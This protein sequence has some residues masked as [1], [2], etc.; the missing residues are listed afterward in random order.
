MSQTD[1]F[2]SA[3]TKLY[4][5]RRPLK[6]DS[7][8]KKAAEEAKIKLQWDD[9]GRITFLDFDD[10]KKLLELLGSSMLSPIE[11][12]K[13]LEDAKS[14][15]D[16]NMIE[17]LTSPNYGEWL[18]RVY[19]RDGTFIDHPLIKSQYK[20]AGKKINAPIPSGRP[21]WL[22]P[23]NN[24]DFQSGMPFKISLFREK[25]A[26]SWKYWSPEFSVTKLSALAP[27]RGYVTSVGKP[28]FD[29]GIPVDARQPVQMLRECRNSPL[30]PPLPQKILDEAQEII[31]E[32]SKKEKD[33]GKCLDF[34][35]TYGKLFRESKQNLIYKIRE[36]LLDILGSLKIEAISKN[37][38]KLIAEIDKATD[39]FLGKKI[40]ATF[41]E[42]LKFIKSSRKRLDMALSSK[43]DIVFVMGHKNPD[44]D[45]VIS[46]LFEAWRNHLLDGQKVTYVAALQSKK[47]PPEIKALLGKEITES[48][49]KTSEENYNRAK[50][51]GLAR[52]I[53][54]DQNREPEIQKYFISIIDHHA[55]SSIAAVQDISKT[56]EAIGSSSALVVQKML[57]MSVEI[58]ERTAFLLYG[59]TLMDTE[60]RIPHKMTPKDK[61]IMDYLKH[62]SGIKES[63]LYKK[64]MSHLLHTNDPE[65]LFRRDYK[66]D[67]GF[68]FAVAK[69]KRG[70]SKQG[71]VLKQNL[72]DKAVGHAKNNNIEKNLPLTILR[73]TDYEEDNSTVNRERIYTIFNSDASKEFKNAVINAMTSLIKFEFG[74][75]KIKKNREYIEFWGTGMQLSRKK[76]APILEPIVRAFNEYFYSP[77]IKKYIKRD[78]LQK[79]PLVKDAA[80][81]I[82]LELS[83]DLHQRINY[84]T[85]P[86]AKMLG[87][88]LGFS[89]LSLKEYWLSLE[90]A[91]KI[92]DI[93]MIDSLQGSN[94]VEFWDSAIINKKVCIDHPKIVLK[95]KSYQITGKKK[96]VSL[97]YASPGLTHPKYIDKVTGIPK[98]ILPPNNY[99]NPELWRYWAP[100][101]NL[102]IPTRSYIFLL[103]QPCW[104]GKVHIED[105]FPNLGIRPCYTKPKLPKLRVHTKNKNLIIEIGKEGEIIKYIWKRG[106]QEAEALTNLH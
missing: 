34:I 73:I 6:L 49:L 86:E 35:N 65:I 21:G 52:W 91:V 13:A 17:E 106:E 10:A 24:I 38:L 63:L 89:M 66:E 42:F 96:K 2:Y 12:W 36:H 26:T 69:I 104:D 68:G 64:L 100:D 3:S 54:I 83:T 62:K 94:F 50:V 57:G 72:F 92:K 5:A 29:L 59:A 76:T 60:N 71:R 25:H 105:S 80:S 39:S 87:N 85:Y 23:E 101:A 95:N 19:L 75:I 11:Y 47:M 88:K 8:I 22:N 70:F 103:K 55:I 40:N 15:N 9:E 32:Y 78:F 44:T 27:I 61:I 58:D 41:N 18:D 67:W 84:I 20:Y 99:G 56:I 48:M 37:N 43:K 46:S 51:S 98:K 79:N 4:I 1:F 16:A 31:N 93:Q 14:Q 33:I 28:S 74:K 30:E 81:K 82:K 53:S 102:V 77:S 97:P 90:D 7:R 45:T